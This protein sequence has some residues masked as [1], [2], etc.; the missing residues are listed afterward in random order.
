MQ[1]TF[2]VSHSHKSNDE[3]KVCYR[4]LCK[5]SLKAAVMQGIETVNLVHII[6][7]TKYKQN[8][9][10]AICS[11]SKNNEIIIDTFNINL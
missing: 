1:Q 10:S 2:I 4:V 7:P 6:H 11:Q 9:D 3:S 5:K 8:D